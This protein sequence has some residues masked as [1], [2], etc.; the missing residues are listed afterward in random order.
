M[1]ADGK[2]QR[3][4]LSGLLVAAA[5]PAARSRLN[6]T[7]ELERTLAH[8]LETGQSAWPGVEVAPA[9]FIEYL[10][11]RLDDAEPT[12]SLGRLAAADLFL[13]CACATGNPQGLDAFER[14]LFPLVARAI[15]R[16]E[17]SP[18]FADEV[19]QQLRRKLFLAEP[20]GAKPRITEYAG[21]GPLEG[22]LRA[23]ALRTA[24]NLKRDEKPSNDTDGDEALL[25]LPAQERDPELQLI[26]ER[27]QVAFKECFRDAMATLSAEDRNMLRLHLNGG[28][29]VQAIGQHYQLH[30]TTVTRRLAASR[31]AVVEQT[32]QLLRVRLKLTRSEMNG[33]VEALRSQLDLNISQVLGQE[34]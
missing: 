19:K 33:M 18:A 11:E 7:T 24:L 5:S 3:G 30:R 17:P 15:R 21:R 13:A 34:R 6:A 26:R 28:V 23:A 16:I 14:R 20:P 29:G 27:Y 8:I 22:W 2:A 4:S 9:A 1:A 25:E 10:A 32:R 31:T 12:Q